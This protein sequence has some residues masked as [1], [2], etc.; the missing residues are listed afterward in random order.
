M[1]RTDTLNNFLTDVATA[2]RTKGGTSEQLKASEFDTAITNLPSGGGGGSEFESEFIEWLESDKTSSVS[3]KPLPKNATKI[4]AYSFYKNVNLSITSLPPNIVELGTYA[5]SGCEKLALTALPNGIEYIPNYCF[6]ACYALKQLVMPKAIKRIGQ[7][8]FNQCTNVTE[9]DFSS[10][11]QVPTL[12]NKN[13]FNAINASC[14]IK[15]PSALYD[16]WVAATNWVNYADK[17]VAV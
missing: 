1:A 13:G 9:Y 8:T 10:A 14:V 17:I 3:L 4:G 5:F 12:D 7:M 11:T 2:I 15:V 16:E 6:A